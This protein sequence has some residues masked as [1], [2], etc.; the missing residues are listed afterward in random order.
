LSSTSAPSISQLKSDQDV[1]MSS[2]TQEAQEAWSFSGVGTN[3]LVASWFGLLTGLLEGVLANSL[4]GVSGFAIRVSPEILWIAPAFDLILFTLIGAAVTLLFRLSGR[5]FS[6]RWEVGLFSTLTMFCLL[7]LLGKIHQ[8]AAIALSLGAGT[9]IAR[10]FGK[11]EVRAL[12]FFRRSGSGLI[13]LAVVLGLTGASWDVGRERYLAKK[14]PQ[15][16]PG[17]PNVLLVTLDT[18]R[19]DHVSSYGYKRTT[20][21]NIDRIAREGVLFENAFANSSWTLPAHASVFTGRL[22]Y[23][24]KADWWEPLTSKYPTIAEALTARGYL[25][26]AFTANTSYVAPEWGL[27]RGFSHFEAHGSSL[28]DDATNTVFG[29]KIA[30][31]LLPRLGYFDIPGRKRASQVNQEFFRWL[32]RANGAP[33]FA[34]LNFFDIHDPYLSVKSYRTRFS[35]EPTEGDLVNFQFQANTFRRKPVLSDQEINSE[36]DGYDSCLAYLDAQ[37]G[38]LFTELAK[39]GLDKN[40]IVIVTSDHGEAF[41]NHDLFGHGNSL[42]LETLHVPLIFYWPTH[43]PAGSRVPDVVSLRDIPSTLM[44]LLGNT[45]AFPGN[46]LVKLWTASQEAIVREPVLSELT[47]E[48]FKNGPPNYPVAK[49]GLKSLVTENWHF[50]LSDSGSAELYAWRQ[51]P[52]EATNEAETLVGRSVVQELK[53]KLN[54][55]VS[56][57]SNR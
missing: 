34:F 36:I 23:E 57:S 46:S 16:Q 52:K 54:S 13:V 12:T 37:M 3:L 2:M 4:R 30:L 50:I 22:P 32:D 14:L 6:L 47:A 24:H 29:K 20:T 53:Q 7:L 31:T 10:T 35:D 5:S 9:Q 45:Q 55:L 26:A 19:A 42:Y 51:D 11:R 56:A 41:G 17:S 38:E 21:P 27:A 8:I 15:P 25:T 43:L 18:L 33:F 1:A 40:T 28:I 48:R 39:R 44:E 49:G